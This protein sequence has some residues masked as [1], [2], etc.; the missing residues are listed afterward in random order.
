MWVWVRGLGGTGPRAD[1]AQ[2]IQRQPGAL[3]AGLRMVSGPWWPRVSG[4]LPGPLTAWVCIPTTSSRT[5]LGACACLSLSLFRAV[6]SLLQ[7]DKAGQDICW[8]PGCPRIA[9][10]APC[11][12]SAPEPSLGGG[13]APWQEVWPGAHGTGPSTWPS[14]WGG[15]PGSGAS[16]CLGRGPTCAGV[17]CTEW[18]Q[19]RLHTAEFPAVLGVSPRKTSGDPTPSASPQVS[20]TTWE[21]AASLLQ[22]GGDI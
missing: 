14:H 15:G 12:T 6:L 3:G 21:A 18:G 16:T 13:A 5:T 8:G 9:S 20:K 17:L 7:F 10:E 1:R 2:L 11:R 22:E 4:D 19:G